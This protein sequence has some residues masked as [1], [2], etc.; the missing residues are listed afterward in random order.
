VRV[1]SNSLANDPNS[2]I[3]LRLLINSNIIAANRSQCSE[4]IWVQINIFNNWIYGIP[5]S[6][7]T[8][9]TTTTITILPLLVFSPVGCFTDT[10]VW[11]LK[12]VPLSFIYEINVPQN[13]NIWGT[14]K[15]KF[16]RFAPKLSP[17]TLLQVYATGQMDIE[18]TETTH[19]RIMLVKI[20]DSLTHNLSLVVS[21]SFHFNDMVW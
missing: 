16:R 13:W 9:V 20:I 6:K 2:L 19:C 11:T 4:L 18:W 15:K 8:F 3:R 14:A 17:Q 10:G 7:Y 5:L 12:S 1:E 21:Y